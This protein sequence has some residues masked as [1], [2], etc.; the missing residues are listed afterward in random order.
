M[1]AQNALTIGRCLPLLA[2]TFRTQTS[3][4]PKQSTDTLTRASVDGQVRQGVTVEP[5]QCIFCAIDD[6]KLNRVIARN[7]TFYA[8]LDNFPAATGH[9]EIVP[10]RHVVSYFDL[11]EREIKDGYRLIR[12][13]RREI[14]RNHGG[15]P[16]GYTIGVNEGKA[17]GRTV[18]HL[19]I[20]LIP[21][22]V[23]DVED[24]RGGIRQILPNSDPDS[25]AP[26][27]DQATQYVH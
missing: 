3:F 17:A 8:R 10:K 9:V 5:T 11:S 23:G 14:E 15:A 12:A 21:R 27:T 1:K 20:H 22:H 7:K 4:A 19:H 25:W 18:D 24:P 2:K 16:D 6:R 26:R 13:A